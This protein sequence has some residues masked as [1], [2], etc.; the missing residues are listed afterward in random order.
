MNCGR[1][2]RRT[3]NTRRKT[4]L[5]IP[6]MYHWPVFEKYVKKMVVECMLCQT[7]VRHQKIKPQRPALEYLDSPM[8]C[9]GLG[10]SRQNSTY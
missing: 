8:Q 6:A 9:M 3:R 7:H 1:K 4:T 2:R 10:F 5:D